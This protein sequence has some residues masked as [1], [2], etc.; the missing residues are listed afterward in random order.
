MIDDDDLHSSI[1]GHGV[2]F[3]DILFLAKYSFCGFKSVNF[4]SPL[5]VPSIASIAFVRVGS[6]Q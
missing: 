2:G 3:K 5:S 4:N 1:K 6:L